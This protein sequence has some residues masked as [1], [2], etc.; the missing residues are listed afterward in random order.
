MDADS[1]PAE[2]DI[3]M[4]N[5][6]GVKSSNS[7][8]NLND[9]EGAD[10]SFSNGQRNGENAISTSPGNVR[11]N[12]LE[13]TQIILAQNSSVQEQSRSSSRPDAIT[14]QNSGKQ[15]QAGEAENSSSG[16]LNVH[17]NPVKN[18]LSSK[19]SAK[20]STDSL[21]RKSFPFTNVSALSLK[22]NEDLS[23]TPI[24]VLIPFDY[25]N[26]NKNDPQLKKLSDIYE[27]ADRNQMNPVWSPDGKWIAFTDTRYCIWMVQSIGGEPKMVYDNYRKARY[28][29][30]DLQLSG[31]RILGFSP[32]G[33][34][35]AAAMEVI[36]ENKGTKVEIMSASPNIMYTIYRPLSIITIL[37]IATGEKHIQIDDTSSGY[38]SRDGRY[39]VYTR[40]TVSELRARDILTGEDR[41]LVKSAALSPCFSSNGQYILFSQKSFDESIQLFRIPLKGGQAEQVTFR[42][43]NDP[44]FSKMV[45]DCSPDGEW[46]LYTG[47]REEGSTLGI[48]NTITGS[49]RDLL[50]VESFTLDSGKFSPDGKKVCYALTAN[51]NEGLIKKIY[52][53]NFTLQSEAP[54]TKVQEKSSTKVSFALTGNYPNP[55]N[56]TTAIQ[57]TIPSSGL[58][59][60]SVYNVMGQ[61]IRELSFGE[62]AAGSHSIV[63]N[64]KDDQGKTLSTGTYISHLQWGNLTT[65]G[66]MT[67]IK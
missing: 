60:L 39:F 42:S 37:N 23:P 41:L 43:K 11:G 66:R 24:N 21:R 20:A 56:M 17:E 45:T 2:T 28:G 8:R 1:V 32:D 18:E 22:A 30:Y 9:N 7:Y 16:I 67:L 53:C 62:M 13:K 52:T 50:P 27:A 5:D 51:D 35:M 59:K 64:G 31:L 46:V 15:K 40:E 10:P 44:I 38:W 34:E 33:K 29:G 36:D 25:K 61:K 3:V 63:W 19:T 55:F 12:E 4:K 48:Y 54:V 49:V 58:V 14:S 47:L 26:A 6:R 65:T 57:F